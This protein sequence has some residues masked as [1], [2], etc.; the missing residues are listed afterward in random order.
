MQFPTF[1][2]LSRDMLHVK[3]KP[4]LQILKKHIL[5]MEKIHFPFTF[6]LAVGKNLI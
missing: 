5:L 2:N 4:F 6:N 3:I 1:Q